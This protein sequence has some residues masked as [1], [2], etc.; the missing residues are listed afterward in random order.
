MVQNSKMK[1]LC[2]AILLCTVVVGNAKGE[3]FASKLLARKSR[4]ALPSVS[5]LQRPF[6]EWPYYDYDYD[7]DYH[8][9]QD[10]SLGRNHGWGLRTEGYQRKMNNYPKMMR[11][12]DMATPARARTFMRISSVC[13]RGQFHCGGARCISSDKKCDQKKDCD[14][15]RDEHNCNGCYPKPNG[16]GYRGNVSRTWHGDLCVERGV[17]LLNG[18][19]IF[20]EMVAQKVKGYPEADINHNYCRNPDNRPGGPWCYTNEEGTSSEACFN[21]ESNDVRF[22]CVAE[23][24]KSFEGSVILSRHITGTRSSLRCKRLCAYTDTCVGFTVHKRNRECMLRSAI[25]RR[26]NDVNVDTYICY[27]APVTMETAEK[28]S[29]CMKECQGTFGRALD[30][31][32]PCEKFSTSGKRKRQLRMEMDKELS[33]LTNEELSK[34]VDQELGEQ[35]SREQSKEVDQRLTRQMDEEWSKHMDKELS[36][37]LDQDS[38]EQVNQKFSKQMDRED[39][40][41]TNAEEGDEKKGALSEGMKETE[42]EVTK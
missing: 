10:I 4:Y 22:S 17:V 38:R 12:S 7:Y 27:R 11:Y 16:V 36:E 42:K 33:E 5:V 15:G 8:P 19:A 34:Q 30:C 23:M 6:W 24:G 26:V 9:Y 21:C 14:N 20:D 18:G 13:R 2:W 35:V 37:Q 32:S 39:R 28:K 29:L 1:N 40:R 41:H 31:E 25:S 3:D